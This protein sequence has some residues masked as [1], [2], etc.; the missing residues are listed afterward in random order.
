MVSSTAL[1]VSFSADSITPMMGGQSPV[2][3]KLYYKDSNTYRSEAMGIVSIIKDSFVYSLVTDTKKYTVQSLTEMREQGDGKLWGD[4]TE[5]V[6]N[7]KMK[8]VGKEKFQGYK[9]IIYEG[10]ISSTEDASPLHIKLWYSKK[11]EN[12]LKQ[13]MTL[14][15]P[16]GKITSHLENIKIGKQDS[17]LFEIPSGY[18]KVADM[19][20]A[21]GFGNFTMPAQ[22]EGK[23]QIPSEEDMKKMMDQMQNMMKNMK[24]Q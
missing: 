6:K 21:M 4:A 23:N 1:A 15:A 10:D 17:N 7:N 24:A 18:T 2:M 20:E 8:K 22:G 3:G 12:M 16:M 9:C 13:E 14:P 11:L 5:M 19:S